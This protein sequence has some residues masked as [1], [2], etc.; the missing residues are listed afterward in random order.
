MTGKLPW[1][2]L[3]AKDAINDMAVRV[4]TSA[5]RGMFWMLI[6]AQW[7]EDG[8]PD[9]PRQLRVLSMEDSQSAFNA[10]WAGALGPLFPIGSDGL[11]RN[12]RLEKVAKEQL[13]RARQRTKI[14]QGAA[15]ARWDYAG[16]M[17]EQEAKDEGIA[18]AVEAWL[19]GATSAR[20]KAMLAR[21]KKKVA[22]ELG[23]SNGSIGDVTRAHMER[24]AL[25]AMLTEL[26]EI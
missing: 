9:N 7:E 3:Y 25:T 18:E 6:F 22:V 20:R 15:R 13:A 16:A 19:E 23:P 21:A 4:M 12:P 5:E 8:L 10:A 2:P 11:R 17:K 1:F 26:E 14:A 24:A